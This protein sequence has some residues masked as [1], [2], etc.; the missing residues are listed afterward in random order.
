MWGVHYYGAIA[1]DDEVFERVETPSGQTTPVVTKG[2]AYEVT[3]DV[4]Y[5]R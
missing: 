2:H 5:E 4:L 1:I 3:Q